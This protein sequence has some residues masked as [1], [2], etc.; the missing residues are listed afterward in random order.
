M[1]FPSRVDTAVPGDRPRALA[2]AV[3]VWLALALGPSPSRAEPPDRQ[4]AEWAILMGGSVRIEGQV[5]R[6]GELTGLPAG[7]FE[8]EMVDLVGTN[9]N[10]PELQRLAGLTRLK[11]LHL[12]GP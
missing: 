5:G 7:N 11:T 3:G 4:V 8:V 9:I 10:P 2:L 12:P 6:I 1:P